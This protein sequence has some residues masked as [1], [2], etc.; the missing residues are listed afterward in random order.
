MMR[1]WAKCV[2]CA[3]AMSWAIAAVIALSAIRADAQAVGS[4]SIR[5]RITDETGAGVPGVT[6]TVSSPSLQLR[7]RAAVSENGGEYQFRSLALGTYSLRVELTGFQAVLREGIELSAGFEARVDVTLKLSSVQETITVSG[8]SPVI[9]VSSTNISSNLNRE[10]L[11]A[12][13]TSR[14]LG[15]AI[16]MA[17]GVRYSGAID[18]GGNRTGQFAN[19]GSNFG[20]NQQSPFLEGINTRLFEGGSMAYLDQ[21]ALDDIQVTAV[22]SSAE[23]ATPGVAWT[24]V[25]KS[26]GN[27]FHGLFSYDGQYPSLQS[28][29]VDAAL[30]NQGLDPSG[31]SIKSYLDATA[32]LGGRIVR[33]K[34]W[35]FAA[36]RSIKRVSNELGFYGGPG[37]DGKYAT[38]DDNP[39]ATRTMWNPGE[40]LKVSYQPATAHRIVGFVSRSIKNERQRGAS[41]FVPLESTWNYWYDPTPWKFEYQWTASNR[42]MVNAMYGDSSYLAQWRPQDGSD[43]AGNPMTSDI[44]TGFTSG[45]AAV[46]RNPNKNHQINASM[47]YYPQRTLLGRHE[48]KAGF[49]YYISV[50]G[51][52]YLNLTSG[53]YTR[54]LD[55]GKA[56]QIRTE[57]R[58]VRADSKLDNPNLFFTDTWRV[59][60]RLTTNLGVR[61]EHH[62]LFSQGG[63]KTP[64]QFGQAATYGDMEILTW[65]GAAPRAGAA[66]DIRGNGK[67]VLKGQWGRYLHLIAANAGSSF[68]PA[69]V[70]ATTYTWHDLNSNLLYDSGEVNLDPNGLDFVSLSQRSSASGLSTSPR[71][72]VNEDLR[73]P[74]TDETSIT[75]EQELANKMAV[76]GLVVYKRISD[77]YANVQLLRPYSVWNIPITRQDPGPDSVLGNSDDGGLVTFY[78][79]DR[80]YRGAAFDPTTPVNRDSSRD[81]TYKGFE[82][83]LTKRQA[84]NWMALGSFQMIKNHIWTGTSATPSNPNQEIFAIDDTWDWSGKV[85]G[86]YRAPHDI[87]LSAIY[88]FLAGT[89]RQRTYQFRS[90]PNATTVTIPLEPIGA[91]RD[92]DQHVVNVRA[93]KSLR[94]GA[95]RRL[96]LAFD[97]F[98][99]FNVNTAT[100]IRYVSSSTYGAISAILP[101]RI[102]RIG[103]EITF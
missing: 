51:V 103:A 56:Y 19:G 44:N 2:R 79:F 24:G 70:T 22:G 41:R 7:E 14:S 94:L 42:V 30:I 81:D 1:E 63:V 8:Q 50:Y 101:P 45:P 100:T 72:F 10:L 88:N 95:D 18:V 27:Q 37:P 67:T 77:D 57:D 48:L 61:V 84:G 39:L 102:A 73:Q 98:N 12:I 59:N 21:R 69:T 5:G 52:D 34:L 49:Q 35:F 33:D 80:A 40:T 64:T 82:L 91:Q 93:A 6:V 83:T 43:V 66:W 55:G 25:V 38:V 29:N 58:P 9:D 47:T 36:Y 62:H 86:Q 11:D 65:N 53:N 89:P 99:L 28:G 74:H 23:F 85:M 92:P 17:P 31:N 90:V 15:E 32:Q 26:G 87:N 71:P 13:P 78:D 16:A 3:L 68:N 97:V 76:R 54:I 4:A 75:I 60:D 20:S 96:S 46:A